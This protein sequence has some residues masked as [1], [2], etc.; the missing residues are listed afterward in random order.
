MKSHFHFFITVESVSSQMLLQ[1]LRQMVFRQQ[2]EGYRVDGSKVPSETTATTV[3]SD[4]RC[5]GLHSHA[6]G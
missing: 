3:V 5:V 4:V 2:D 6:E 1:R